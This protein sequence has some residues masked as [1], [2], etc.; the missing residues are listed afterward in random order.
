[1]SLD[2][3]DVQKIAHLARLQIND[4]DIP[5]YAQNLTNILDLVDQVADSEGVILG[6]AKHKGL[7]PLIN[8]A[9]EDLDALF[10]PRLDLDDLV[11]V[12]FCVALILFDLTFNDI[13]I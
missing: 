1:M 10:L 4:A 7:L 5:E 13:V 11:E 3:T 12:G 8:V 2:S 6:G 9:H